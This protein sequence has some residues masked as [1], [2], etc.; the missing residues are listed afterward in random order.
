[1]STS[2]Q[3]GARIGDFSL[4]SSTGQTLG[5]DSFLGKVP[6]VIVFVDP[7]SNEDRSLLAEL[8]S[9]HKDFGSERSQILTVARITARDT[10]QIA[11]D[12]GLSVP[13]LADASGAMA[14]NF[15]AE[16]ADGGT[17]RVAVVADKEG[18][19]VRR[20]DPLPIEDDP[21]AVT[22]ALLYAVRAIGSGSLDDVNTG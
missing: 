18:R 2:D 10:R 3:T 12:M 15:D 21:T 6:M 19:M 20:F 16:D 14:R 9:R 4:P 7:G 22:E 17:R 8:S 13:L 5:L 11:D 1:M